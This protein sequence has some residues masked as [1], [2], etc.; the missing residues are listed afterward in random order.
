M[1]YANGTTHYNLPQTVGTDKRDWSDTNQAFA[2][3]DAA[4]YQASETASSSA[5][6]ITSI[7][8]D[9]STLSTNIT[10]LTGVV[11]GNTS[12][13]STINESLGLINNVLSQHT[14]SIS[15]KLDSVAIAEPY[16]T[17]KQYSIG[18]IVVHAGQRYK[19]VTAVS[20]PEPFDSDKWIGED[21]QT[22]FN[23]LDTSIDELN[24]K[25]F[26]MIP[27]TITP[28]AGG[29]GSATFDQ[30]AFFKISD[31][32]YG[33]TFHGHS[34]TQG[35]INCTLPINVKYK[36]CTYGYGCGAYTVGNDTNGIIIFN[37]QTPTTSI[38][39]SGIVIE[40]D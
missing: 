12:A 16:D 19:C 4:L 2:D 7:E 27:W 31:K 14:T 9:L 3:I 20:V 13:I 32:V 8:A 39:C 22:I 29:S 28:Q 10:S 11:D 30:S 18:D 24:S 26:E 35:T 25:Q 40:S 21:V 38:M 1:S 33:F 17:T 36:M 37:D 15:N 34:T 23:N 5:T 6:E